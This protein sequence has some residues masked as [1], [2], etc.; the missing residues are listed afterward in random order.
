MGQLE[1]MREA[2]LQIAADMEQAQR[3]AAD[4]RARNQSEQ[5]R[6]NKELAKTHAELAKV[7]K[8]IAEERKQIERERAAVRAAF[9]DILGK[10]VA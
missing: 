9:D 10:Q 8:E 1:G 7:R 6:A 5:E 4:L 2:A 3:L